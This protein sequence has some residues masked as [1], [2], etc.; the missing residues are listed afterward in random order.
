M[1]TVH[2]FSNIFFWQY[3]NISYVRDVFN[4][5]KSRAGSNA[6]PINYFRMTWGRFG[7][8]EIGLFFLLFSENLNE[9]FSEI[10]INFKFE[11]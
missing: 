1:I 10:E 11:K 5:T 2:N 3:T 9:L 6:G 7:N 8:S 4:V